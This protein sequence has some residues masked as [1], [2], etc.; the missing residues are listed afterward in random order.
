M[1]IDTA[2]KNYCTYSTPNVTISNSNHHKGTWSMV[3]VRREFRVVNERSVNL[4]VDR[5]VEN[6]W[7]LCNG[8]R[9]QHLL[10]LNDSFSVNGAQE[11]A[12]FDERDGK[13]IDSL[14]VSWM[15]KDE[16]TQAIARLLKTEHQESAKHKMPSIVHPEGSCMHCE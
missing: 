8:F 2:D 16:L 13:E 1:T 9:Y 6:T 3:H 12:V 10:F 5:L 4:F 15:S 7:C 11:F 14:T